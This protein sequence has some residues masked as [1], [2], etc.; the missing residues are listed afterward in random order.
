[1]RGGIPS[2]VDSNPSAT[3]VLNAI[4]WSFRIL[5]TLYAMIWFVLIMLL[6]FP[7]VVVASFWGKFK[8]GNF[9]YHI[10]RVWSAAWFL[11]V[12]IRH[13]NI[14]RHKPDPNSQ[15]IFVINH[16]SYL[17]AAVLVETIRQPFRPLGKV[18][19]SRI[20][21]FGYIYKMCVVMVDRSNSEHRQRSIRQLKSVLKKGISI[22]IFPEGTFNETDQPLK[23]F[24][25]GAFRIAIETQTPIQ[26]ILFL[27]TYERMHHRHLFSLRPGRSR[28]LFLPTVPV[29][30]LTLA[31]V[32]E[33]KEKVYGIMEAALTEHGSPNRNA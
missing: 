29:E 17:D 10:L 19:M 18:E 26:P 7:F 2:R 11:L 20:P 3:S 24:Y 13:R 6:I 16:I 31:G 4:V 28:S 8:G 21:I 1:M 22:M 15:Y 9:I 33:L 30:G 32:K 23:E 25:D 5:Y 27:D 12:G 14:Y